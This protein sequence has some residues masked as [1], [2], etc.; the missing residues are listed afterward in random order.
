MPRLTCLPGCHE[1]QATKLLA[2][3]AIEVLAGRLSRFYFPG[4]QQGR[5][6]IRSHIQHE[7]CK[8]RDRQFLEVWLGGIGDINPEDGPECGDQDLVLFQVDADDGTVEAL[9]LGKAWSRDQTEED[10]TQESGE[11][12]RTQIRHD[13]HSFV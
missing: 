1:R 9:V 2:G 5:L 8:A 3:R 11:K 13:E 7:I 4:L 12:S 6:P 10:E